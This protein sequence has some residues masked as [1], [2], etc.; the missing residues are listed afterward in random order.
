MKTFYFAFCL[1]FSL[2][3]LG[4]AS[5]GDYPQ[6]SEDDV[7]C[8]NYAD[9]VDAENPLPSYMLVHCSGKQVLEESRIKTMARM[10]DWSVHL[11]TSP[12]L[13]ST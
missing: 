5:L 12:T 11:G 7:D 10:M 6:C 8:Q 9:V 4:S 2:L 3:G 1:L 13:S